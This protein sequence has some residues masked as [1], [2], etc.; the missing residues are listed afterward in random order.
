ML[1]FFQGN[2]GAWIAHQD[3]FAA[4]LAALNQEHGEDESAS[5]DKKESKDASEKSGSDSEEE[6]SA[7]SL[8]E[9]S[10]KMRK[11]VQ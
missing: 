10:K 1:I 7:K 2:D 5:K 11:R 8:E 4:V 6:E 3:D 9:R